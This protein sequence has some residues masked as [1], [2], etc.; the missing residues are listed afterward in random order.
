MVTAMETVTAEPL[1]ARDNQGRA[2]RLSTQVAA[3]DR[4]RRAGLIRFALGL[5]VLSLVFCSTADTASAQLFK[6]AYERRMQR[7]NEK[8]EKEKAKH[9]DSPAVQ[10]NA[11][12]PEGTGLKPLRRVQVERWLREDAK[13]SE[14][15]GKT[16]AEVAADRTRRQ[17]VTAAILL[18]VAG[19]LSSAS[20]AMNAAT[21]YE[22]YSPAA[23]ALPFNAYQSRLRADQM[24]FNLNYARN[25]DHAPVYP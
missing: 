6:K 4:I 8:L 23:A 19:G 10:R 22:P 11:Y 2:E 20:A 25:P 14:R 17:Q 15:T 13:R 18:G 24:Q 3:H 5:A 7:E 16:M 1:F 21:P 9:P 12:N